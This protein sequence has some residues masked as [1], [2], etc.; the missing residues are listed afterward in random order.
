[1]PGGTAAADPAPVRRRRC[2][3]AR[4]TRWICE[5]TATPGARSYFV[6]VETP[7]GPRTFFTESTRVR[8]PA[9][10][11]NADVDALPHVF[12]PGFPQ[13]VT[14]SAVDSNY[15]DWYRTHNDAHLGRRD[16]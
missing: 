10:L 1:M 3:T 15:Y 5:W 16:S 13:A 12:I 11:R 14:V 8:L 7:Y 6:R 4:A 2:S 9:M